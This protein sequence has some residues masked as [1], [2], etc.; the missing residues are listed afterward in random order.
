MLYFGSAS[1][2]L[3]KQFDDRFKALES[4]VLTP[5][6]STQ[7][8]RIWD[9]CRHFP[10]LENTQIKFSRSWQARHQMN[11]SRIKP[12]MSSKATLVSH[13]T[14]LSGTGGL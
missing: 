11:T 8:R 7:P 12:N 9:K 5:D 1:S 13:I 6:F 14:V 10:P 3:L 2:K 4:S